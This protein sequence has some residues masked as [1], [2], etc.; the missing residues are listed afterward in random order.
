MLSGLKPLFDKIDKYYNE[1]NVSLRV[2]QECLQKIS[3]SLR[4]TPDDRIR[5]EHIRDACQEA[6]DLLK[7]EVGSRC[8]LEFLS[9]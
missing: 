5:W 3:S 7:T 2:E 8:L 9:R 4:V 6:Y 1:V